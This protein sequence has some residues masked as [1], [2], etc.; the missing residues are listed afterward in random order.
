MPRIVGEISRELPVA[1]EREVA[2]AIVGEG[3]DDVLLREGAD[4]QR[5][6][7]Q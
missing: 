6:H 1:R 5:R 4:R 2:G 7:R 3:G